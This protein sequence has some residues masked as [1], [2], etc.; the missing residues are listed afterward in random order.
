M[1]LLML[2]LLAQAEIS[3][4]VAANLMQPFTTASSEF[5]LS[6]EQ[7]GVQIRCTESQRVRT[8]QI[9]CSILPWQLDAAVISA[10]RL[11]DATMMHPL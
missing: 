6:E 10:I 4:Q 2:V 7:S 5:S 11:Y 1:H 3:S 8:K 9:C